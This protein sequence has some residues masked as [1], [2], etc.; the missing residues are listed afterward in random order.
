VIRLVDTDETIVLSNAQARTL[1]LAL[2]GIKA[3]LTTTAATVELDRGGLEQ[4]VD[5]ALE[6][7]GI[8]DEIRQLVYEVMEG[9]E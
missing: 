2:A 5:V 6:A 1:V 3:V 7:L 9:I 4:R 8:E